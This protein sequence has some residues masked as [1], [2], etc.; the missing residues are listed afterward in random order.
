MS[1][2]YS[3]YTL[4]EL[5]DVY[6]HIDKEQYPE[7]FKRL[8]DEI[9]KRQQGISTHYLDSS[10]LDYFEEDDEDDDE[11]NDFIIDFESSKLTPSRLIAGVLIA[12]VNIVILSYLLPKYHVKPLADTHQFMTTID[13]AQC[14]KNSTLRR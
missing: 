9:D 8:C 10:N 2:N 3:S 1:I 12:L 4:D 11:S 6:H 13:A 14:K 7:R 5:I